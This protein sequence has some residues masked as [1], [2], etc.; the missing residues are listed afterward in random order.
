MID[1]VFLLLVFFMLASNLSQSQNIRLDIPEA[2]RGVVPR[3]RPDRYVVNI[4]QDGTL[5]SGMT[6]VELDDLQGLVEQ[7]LAENPL[8]K[9]YLRADADAPHREVRRVMQRMAQAG[10]D[11]FLFGVYAVDGG[12]E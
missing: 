12:A 3:E 10:I 1:M 8:T 2:T 7:A 9:V 11:D 6:P 4:T 5:F